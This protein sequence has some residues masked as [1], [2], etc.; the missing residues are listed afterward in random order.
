[1]AATGSDP[2]RR[3]SLRPQRGH[4]LGHLPLS[5]S[6]TLALATNATSTATRIVGACL[7]T[8]RKA[9]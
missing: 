7:K 8:L 3:Y 1:M 6:S 5:T 4:T 9:S 2:T